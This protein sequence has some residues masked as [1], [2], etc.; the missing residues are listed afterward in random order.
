MSSFKYCPKAFP[1][2]SGPGGKDNRPRLIRFENC[3]NLTFSGLT[4]KNPAFWGIHLVDCKDV[5]ITAVT[6]QMR[7]NNSN[8]DG[9]DIDGCENVLLENSEIHSRKRRGSPGGK[10]QTTVLSGRIDLPIAGQIRR[11]RSSR[12]DITCRRYYQVGSSSVSDIVLS[13]RDRVIGGDILLVLQR[14]IVFCV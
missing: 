13:F 3:Q 6:L 12:N 10:L 7:D 11:K 8:N 14:Y 4:Y 1:K 9:F 2:R 5:H